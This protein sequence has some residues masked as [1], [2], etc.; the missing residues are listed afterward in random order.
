[1]TSSA[2]SMKSGTTGDAWEKGARAGYA[3]SGLLHIALGVLIA[4]L[5]FGGSAGEEASS[6]QAL[7]SI[8]DNTLGVIVLWFAVVAFAALGLWQL[9][10]GFRSHNEAKD[11]VKAFGKAGVYLVLAF[12]AASIAM[13]SSSGGGDEQAQGIV[14]QV[15]GWPGGQLIVGAIAIGILVTGVFHV[16]KGARKKFLENLRGVPSGTGGTVKAL[17]MAGYIAKG[18][19][20]TIVGLL[21]GYSAITADPDDA[22]GLDGAVKSLLDLPGGQVIVVLVGAGF[23]AYGVYSLVRA[24]YGRL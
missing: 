6:S 14:A 22:K 13:G 11:R 9:A 2:S 3:V 24:R 8:S 15:L 17:G 5:A 4:Q 7:S 12:T 18:A 23:A 19:A 21:F 16:V 1:M 10:D 20:L